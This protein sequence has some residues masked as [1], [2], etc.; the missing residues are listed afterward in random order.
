MGANGVEFVPST[1]NLYSWMH[2]RCATGSAPLGAPTTTPAASIG[3]DTV[4]L[5]TS[6]IVLSVSS[7]K[8]FAKLPTHR[9]MRSTPMSTVNLA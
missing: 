7:T 4:A 8:R 3:S 2:L 5:T 9:S 6:L 1:V